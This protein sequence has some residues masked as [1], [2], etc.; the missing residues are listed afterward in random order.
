MGKNFE[1]SKYTFNLFNLIAAYIISYSVIQIL[2]K[3]NLDNYLLVRLHT[4]YFLGIWEWVI[5]IF[6]PFNSLDNLA[7]WV[8]FSWILS[9]SMFLKKMYKYRCILQ[10]STWPFS[11]ASNCFL[12]LGRDSA[13]FIFKTLL[14]G[15]KDPIQNQDKLYY[16]H[17]YFRIQ[18]KSPNCVQI[19]SKIIHVT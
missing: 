9:L 6:K 5:S 17:L 10:T 18:W 12:F 4:L 8:S 11:S 3:K 7:L 15:F 14:A 2:H 16:S 19:V 1:R 13:V